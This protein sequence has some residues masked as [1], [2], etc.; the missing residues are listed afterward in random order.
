MSSALLLAEFM[1]WKASEEEK[2]HTKYVKA[3]QD[4]RRSNG[5]VIQSYYC[6]R[7]GHYKAKGHG[8]CHRK[9]KGSVKIGYCPAALFVTVK[10]SGKCL[11]TVSTVLQ[12]FSW[13]SCVFIKSPAIS[14]LCVYFLGQI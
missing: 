4:M 13:S 9:M 10:P 3:R 2:T 6:H 5:A 14:I 12:F 11:C 7:S 8:L 1:D